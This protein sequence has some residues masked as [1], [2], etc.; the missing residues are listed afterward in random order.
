MLQKNNQ[1]KP[2]QAW[3]KYKYNPRS[4]LLLEEY[5]QPFMNTPFENNTIYTINGKFYLNV[6]GTT[7]INLNNDLKQF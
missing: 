7:A 6:N 1:T 2:H 5:F 3:Q 4:S